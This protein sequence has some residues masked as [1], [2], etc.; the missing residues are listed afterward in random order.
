M[1]SHELFFK[2]IF[3]E[4]CSW[5]ADSTRCYPGTCADE[6]SAN[7]QCAANFEGTHCE[8]SRLLILIQH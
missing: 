3:T 4:A 5:R 6:L 2:L 1:G 7:C 8:K